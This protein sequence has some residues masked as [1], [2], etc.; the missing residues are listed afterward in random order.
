MYRPLRPKN[1]DKMLSMTLNRRTEYF[2]LRKSAIW[3]RLQT[4]PINSV[5]NEVLQFK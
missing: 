1:K 3:R 2:H 4:K 5:P